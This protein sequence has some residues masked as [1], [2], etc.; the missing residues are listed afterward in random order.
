M[1]SKYLLPDANVVAGYYLPRSLAAMKARRRI[2][3]ILDSVRSGLIAVE[4][5]I[6]LVTRV[7]RREIGALWLLVTI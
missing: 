6:Q 5:L 2:E 1:P 3:S 7:L 4:E